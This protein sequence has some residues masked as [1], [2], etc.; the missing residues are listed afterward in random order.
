[1]GPHLLGVI[2]REI[3]AVEGYRYSD[4]LTGLNAEG[5]VWTEDAMVAWLEDPAEFAPGT[6]MN[7]K[8]R[9]EEDRR[10]IAA[11]LAQNTQ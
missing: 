10:L 7:F 6:K 11:W 5:Q 1:V 2:G 4:A 8:V 9:E 3:G